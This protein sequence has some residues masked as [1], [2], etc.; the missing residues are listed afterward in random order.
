LQSGA[1]DFVEKPVNALELR[2]RVRSMLRI[3][4]QYDDLQQLLQV[5]SDLTNMI[6]HDL[7]NPLMT[8]ML[9]SEI[10]KRTPLTEKQQQKVD[11]IYRNGQ[12]AISLVD[13][14]LVMAKIEGGF[15]SVE[16]AEM[17]L[18]LIIQDILEDFQLIADKYGVFWVTDFPDQT[19]LINSDQNLLKRIVENLLANAIKFS[20][21]GQKIIIRLEYPPEMKVR[22]SIIDES[23]G[24][25]DELKSIVFNRFE[26]GY[27][28][29]DVKQTGL[30]LAFCKL[31]IEALGGTILVQDNQPQGAIFFIVEI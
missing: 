25:S 13:N 31:A 4:K 17:D 8:I 3:K 18:A 16:Y 30:G 29:N 14:Q 9:A 15:L 24:V 23:E 7:R 1:D 11:Q 26:V 22:L 28:F 6:I 27:S 20:N 19:R 12:Q 2:A 21:S 10:L 5:R